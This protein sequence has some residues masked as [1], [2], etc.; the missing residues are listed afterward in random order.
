[1]DA[2]QLPTKQPR[3]RKAARPA[4]GAKSRAAFDAWLERGLH[5]M[6]DEVVKE[7]VP[8]ELLRLIEEERKG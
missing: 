3:S 4:P 5:Q 1:M 7:S 6:Y 8:K 2:M